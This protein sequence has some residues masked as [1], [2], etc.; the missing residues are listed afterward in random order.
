MSYKISVIVPVYKTEKYLDK[1][2]QSIVE[3]T[4][5]NLEIILVDDS[6][7]DN[8]PKMCDEWA[9]KD[10]RIKVLHIENKGVANARNTALKS[11]TGDY[12]SFVDNDDYT[13]PDMLETLYRSLKENNS[14]IAIC[15]F[16]GGEYDEK[17]FRN[18]NVKDALKYIAMGDYFFGVLWNKMYKREL[19]KDIEMPNLTCCEDLVFNYFVFKNAGSIAITTDKKYHYVINLGSITKSKFNL[20]AFDAVKSK[21]IILNDVEGT[22]IEPYA[23]RG[24]INSCFVV[25][26]GAIK[27]NKYKNEINQL[28]NIILSHKKEIFTKNMYTNGEK[29]KTAVLSISLNLYCKIVRRHKK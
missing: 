21:E 14:D 4:Y 23:V 13:D 29:V 27:S 9:K 11:A 5:E 6:S 22:D 8:C 25:L 17:L 15:G 16:Y 24:L 1:C 12:I 2:V 20:G 18:T 3:Q 26:S 28:R 19:L 10:S 7:P